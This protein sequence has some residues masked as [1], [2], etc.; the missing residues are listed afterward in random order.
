MNSGKHYV[1][2][3]SIFENY[4]IRYRTQTACILFKNEEKE[5]VFKCNP[6][7][8]EF[9]YSASKKYIRFKIRESWISQS[10]YIIEKNIFASY[11]RYEKDDHS[12]GHSFVS[13]MIEKTV[14]K[15]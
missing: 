8:G 1:T 10:A 11:E 12:E 5:I 13:P 4:Q 6:I 9:R 3:S 2:P 15:K 7:D 14:D